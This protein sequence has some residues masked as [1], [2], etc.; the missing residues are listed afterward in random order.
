MPTETKPAFADQDDLTTS[1]YRMS[2]LVD[3]IY[4][5][6]DTNAS[7][8]IAEGGLRGIHSALERDIAALIDAAEAGEII[9]GSSKAA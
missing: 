1:L 8:Q 3:A 2:G 9:V 6:G 4:A 7:T 5:V